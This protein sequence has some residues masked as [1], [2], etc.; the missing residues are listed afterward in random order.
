MLV[1][2]KVTMVDSPFQV[3][4]LMEQFSTQIQVKNPKVKKTNSDNAN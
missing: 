2:K 3:K 1:I 4:Q